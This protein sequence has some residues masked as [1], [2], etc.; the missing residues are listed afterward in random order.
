MDNLSEIIVVVLAIPLGLIFGM[1]PEIFG[2]IIVSGICGY[3]AGK[4]MNIDPL[5]SGI[6]ASIVVG[7][8]YLV[9]YLSYTPKYKKEDEKD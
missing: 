4:I 9:L 7:L 1:M 8:T 3:I 2:T 5:K 6:V